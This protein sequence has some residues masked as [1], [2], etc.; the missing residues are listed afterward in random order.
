MKWF[1]VTVVKNA[2]FVLHIYS[3]DITEHVHMYTPSLTIIQ[4]LA[5][6]QVIIYMSNN[7][8]TFITLFTYKVFSISVNFLS[9]TLLGRN[10]L[11]N[12]FFMYFPILRGE[13]IKGCCKHDLSFKWTSAS[14]YFGPG[15]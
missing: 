2:Y 1:E 5:A 4:I 13:L 8:V 3:S 10:C 6:P 9:F 12:S 15:R 14:R 7:G 11:Y